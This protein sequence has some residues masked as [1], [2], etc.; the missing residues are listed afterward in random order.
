MVT[1]RIA[2]AIDD[3]AQT[4]PGSLTKETDTARNVVRGVVAL[5]V[6]PGLRTLHTV[7]SDQGV[8]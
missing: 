8:V 1:N 5:V 6:W 3:D 2:V 7:A 4:A